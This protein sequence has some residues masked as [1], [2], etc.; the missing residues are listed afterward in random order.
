[1]KVYILEYTRR[2]GPDEMVE[3]VGIFSS[4][5]QAMS[6][7]P[8]PLSWEHHSEDSWDSIDNYGDIW[9][10]YEMGVDTGIEASFP[11]WE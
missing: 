4:P 9:I 8:Y 5:E 2:P 10:V 1:M 3:V 11:T 7:C 6:A